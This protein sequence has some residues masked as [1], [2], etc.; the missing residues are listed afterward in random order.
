[1][2][3][4]RKDEKTE[5]TEGGLCFTVSRTALRYCPV[6]A[7]MSH[8]RIVLLSR[9]IFGAVVRVCD[10]QPVAGNADNKWTTTAARTVYM[11]KPF[12]FYTCYMIK[13]FSVHVI[14]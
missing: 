14:I 11:D 3:F 5:P 6:T 7:V 4:C 13:E 10:T 1:M 8:F 2:T 9:D 12:V